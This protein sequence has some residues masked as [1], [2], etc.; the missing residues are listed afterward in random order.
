MNRGWSVKAILLF[1]HKY[2]KEIIKSKKV[3]ITINEKSYEF[4]YSLRAMFMWES[5]MEKPFEIN[6]LMDT[7]VFCYSCLV[8]NQDNPELDFNTF[9]NACDADPSI[10]EE[11]NQYMTKE[12]KARE[13]MQPKKK[14]RKARSSQ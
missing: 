5:I 2:K 12:M 13:V 10:I 9:L 11:F 6:T 3:M 4:K 7:Y 8:S 1:T 14:V